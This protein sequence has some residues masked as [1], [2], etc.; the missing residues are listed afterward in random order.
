MQNTKPKPDKLGQLIRKF[1]ATNAA[2]LP[3]GLFANKSEL[4]SAHKRIAE[5]EAQ[6]KALSTRP[7]AIA[8]KA[9][10]KASAPSVRAQYK[11]IKDPAARLEFAS[12][13]WEALSNQ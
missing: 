5:L 1:E 4:E 12:K 9:P 10:A 6:V 2:P 8:P 11:A 3:A 7:L 13:N